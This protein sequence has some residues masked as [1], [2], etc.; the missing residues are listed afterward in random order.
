MAQDEVLKAV[1]THVA[2]NGSNFWFE[3]TGAPVAFGKGETSGG[4]LR[5]EFMPDV[6]CSC[7]KKSFMRETDILDVWMDSGASWLAVLG[8][9]EYPCQLYLEGSDQHRGWFQSSL[10]MSVAINGTAPYRT[11]LTH[12][13]VLDDKGRAMHKSLGNVVSPQ[14]VID[15]LG[16]D[17][18][19]L[20][21]ALA[22][23]SDDVR[24][25][26]KLLAGPTDIY[27][28]LRN[29]FKYLLGNTFDFDP[30]NDFVAAQDMPELER[31]V[32]KKLFDLEQT[33]RSAYDSFA[34]R[35]AATSLVDFCN[36]TLSAFY[37]DA[38]KDALY[39]LKKDDP[40]RRASQSVMWEC[41]LRIVN[42]ASPILSFTCEEVWQEV[43]RGLKER[44]SA[45]KLEESVFLYDLAPA[46][47]DYDDAEI[48]KRWERILDIRERVNKKIEE[49][50]AEKI[51]GASL[52]ARVTV[53]AE[54]EE[55]A[56]M[57]KLGEAAWTELLIVSDV[58]I[59]EGSALVV[60]EAARGEKCPRCWRV[61]D[62]LGASKENPELCQ[63]C[64]RQLGD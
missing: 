1:E 35:R 15:K 17:V 49:K 13:F 16:A 58:E 3:K 29:T 40:V 26:D 47:S 45:L 64:V 32:L 33:V 53:C 23:Y 52:K 55:L 30:L 38:R 50:R 46:P 60:V 34:F 48:E 63:R 42:L 43:L 36:L 41:T 62:D 9:G 59:K 4:S 37:L 56:F 54:G 21:V 25:S 24:L 39:T 7:G 10:V 51:I 18:L 31:F 22:D 6:A 8:E 19:R 44:G 28:K 2:K 20:W 57:K 12:G 61:R 5:W 27:R 11:V 14:K